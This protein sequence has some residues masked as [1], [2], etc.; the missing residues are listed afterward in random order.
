MS[1]PELAIRRSRAWIRNADGKA[2]LCA[3]AV[4]GLAAAAASQRPLLGPVAR[5]AG[6]WNVVALVA[7]GLSAVTLAASA[8]FLV[9]ALLPRRPARLPSGDEEGWAYAHTLAR[10]A[11]SKY[12][13]LRRALVLWIVSAGFLVTWIVIAS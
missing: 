9:R 3:T 7:F 11:R 2:G 1:G 5:A 6:V 13:A 8:V 10:V 12:R 4:A